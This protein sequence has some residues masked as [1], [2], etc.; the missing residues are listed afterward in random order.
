MVQLCNSTKEAISGVEDGATILSGGFG[1]CGNPE[2][3]IAAIREKNIKKLTFISNN[4]GTTHL[5]LGILLQNKQIAKMVS[6]YVGENK[7]FERQF[8]N[9]ALEVELIPQGTLAEKIRAAGAGIPAF[10]TPTGVGTQVQRG[11]LAIKYNQ[12]NEVIKVSEK[13]PTK[14]FDGKEYLLE[15]AIKADFALVKACKAD[16][17]GNL[18]FNKTAQ[19]FNSIMCK[20]ARV[21]IVEAEEIVKPGALNPD[22]IHVS[23]IYVDRLVHCPHSQKPIEKLVVND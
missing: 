9:G 8:L 17:A 22:Q 6:S 18:V 2:N 12:N 15:E 21:S 11:G 5:G 13:K 16:T 10:Y 19:N 1:L 3:L 23:G 14:V 7:E 20:A 4:C